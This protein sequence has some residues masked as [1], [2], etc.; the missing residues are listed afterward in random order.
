M[1]SGGALSSALS[2]GL[3]IV[4]QSLGVGEGVA[5]FITGS[6]KES[7]DSAELSRLKRPFYK[8][9]NEYLQ[10]RDITANLAES[11][12]PASTKNYFTQEAQ[13]GLSASI[14]AIMQ[15]GGSP[16]DIA[17]LFSAYGSS[18][19][20]TAAQDAQLKLQNIQYF[21]G[22]NKDLAGQKNIQYGINELQP[23]E[24]QL[25]NLN[26]RKAADE[27]TKWGGI[28]TAIGSLSAAGTSASNSDLYGRLFNGQDT[29]APQLPNPFTVGNY[30]PI[31]TVPLV[32]TQAPQQLQPIIQ[33]LPQ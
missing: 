12:L 6:K 1:P 23:Y 27:Q 29:P 4:S 17:K 13:K 7:E 11:G 3:P 15:G 24:Q 25:K 19:D 20:S 28:N 5:Q 2:N 18:I 8:I 9:Q 30:N 32:P 10:N 14:S 31:P 33:G 26:E 16:T 21:M 22:A